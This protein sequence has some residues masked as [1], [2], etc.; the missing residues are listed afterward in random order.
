MYHK[1]IYKVTISSIYSAFCYYILIFIHKH[2]LLIYQHSSVYILIFRI[3]L[4]V[5]VVVFLLLLIS[6]P[7]YLFFMQCNLCVCIHM[8][9]WRHARY[10]STLL[11][12]YIIIYKLELFPIFSF[13]SNS[14]TKSKKEKRKECLSSFWILTN[15][16]Q[17]VIYNEVERYNNTTMFSNNWRFHL[18]FFFLN[19]SCDALY[20]I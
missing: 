11:W 7:I 13:E 15:E 12:L 16:K 8:I 20:F 2:F 10:L 17:H 14:N 18:F 1:T 9:H 3:N 4:D 5:I 19:E 6:H